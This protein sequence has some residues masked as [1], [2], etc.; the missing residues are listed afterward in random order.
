MQEISPD[1]HI[2][3]GYDGVTLG[4]VS[5][6][7]GLVMIDAPF[8]AED[9]RS[10]RAALLNLG[11]G[12]ERLLINL[13]AHL[14]RTLGARAMDCTVVASEVVAK[15][16]HDRPL[17]FKAQPAETGA[18]WEETNGL[19]SIRWSPPEITFTEKMAIHWDES[20]LLLEQHVGPSA[21]ATWV[22]LP[23]KKVVFVGDALTINEPPFLA[24]ADIPAWLEGLQTLLSPAYQE[25]LIVAGRGGLAAVKDVHTQIQFLQ[26]VNSLLEGLAKRHAPVEAAEALAPTLLKQFPG[27]AHA[28]LWQQRLKYGLGQYYQR[29]HLSHEPAAGTAAG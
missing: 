1:V 18:A 22:V 2:E 20:P 15:V 3:T 16:F 6:P 7:H 10:W 23:V 28:M 4:A 27:E 29:H 24:A 14:D 26:Q 19:G 9:A 17:T 8:R 12:V 21:G 11:G 25:Y 5:C 13:D